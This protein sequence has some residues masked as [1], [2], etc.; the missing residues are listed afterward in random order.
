MNFFIEV[1]H[2]KK[3]HKIFFVMRQCM[4]S[5]AREHGIFISILYLTP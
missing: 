1:Q 4:C 5:E 2:M 3:E